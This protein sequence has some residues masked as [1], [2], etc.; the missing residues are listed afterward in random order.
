MKK[1]GSF[2]FLSI[3]T[4]QAFATN[5]G[6]LSTNRKV[7]SGISSG[8]VYYSGNYPGAVLM[9][10]SIIGEVQ[11]PGVHHM[12]KDTSLNTALGFAGGPTRFA[13]TKDAV[14]NR[15]FNGELKS[16]PLD[17][18]K[19]F[20]EL[21]SQNISIQPNDTIYIPQREAVISDNTFRVVTVLSFI[22]GTVLSAVSI[23]Q[24]TK[25]N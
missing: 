23:H 5:D 2:I 18:D 1:F 4:L 16:I 3:F 22:V 12:P 21:H 7:D 19:H 14:I 10:V 6:Y 24:L 8:S 15:N 17:L 25:S 13:N 11:R 20:R 9:R